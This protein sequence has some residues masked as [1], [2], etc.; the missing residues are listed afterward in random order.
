MRIAIANMKG[1]VG[2]STTAMM[3]AESLAVFHDKRVLVVDCDPQA[4]CS[5]MLLSYH[6]LLNAKAAHKTITNWIESIV[7]KSLHG[8]VISEH[9]A[10]ECIQ[11][12]VSEL[13]NFE[14]SYWNTIPSQGKVSI[15]P[16]TP[17][18]RFAELLFDGKNMNTGDLQNPTM[19][20]KA[21]LNEGL[22]AVETN[23]T[24]TIFDCP[25]GF[26]TLA[27]S[28]L[29]VSDA[30]LTPLTVDPVALWSLKTFW[31]QG[32]R[33]N[34][35]IPSSTPKMA[36][37]TMVRSAGAAEEKQRIRQELSAFSPSARLST[38]IPFRSDALRMVNRIARDSK[39]SF[40]EKYG[41]LRTS[42][43]A[44]GDEVMQKLIAGSEV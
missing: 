26:S 32:L 5:Q 13:T 30:I 41:S 12:D 21:K 44:L 18:L 23:G 39:R 34:L 19:V 17:D 6:G 11:F 29:L 4:N 20:L 24:I 14:E 15:W 9:S 38:E 35:R 1:G 42:V 28:A 22:K 37:L 7:G 31:N 3:L 10:S 8:E 36:L 27:Q 16:A 40:N 2:K 33:D 25:P 43:K